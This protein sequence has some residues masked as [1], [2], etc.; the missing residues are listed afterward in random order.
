[1]GEK[2]RILHLP[3]QYVIGQVDVLEVFV[4]RCEQLSHKFMVGLMTP[5]RK[6]WN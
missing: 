6:Q 3:D 5:R 4:W 1:V 2:L